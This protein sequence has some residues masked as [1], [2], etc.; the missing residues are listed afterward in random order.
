MQNTQNLST[1]NIQPI[2]IDSINTTYQIHS[3]ADNNET[4]I[5]NNDTQTNNTQ[6]NNNET[7][8]QTTTE[9][10]QNETEKEKDSNIIS[11]LLGQLLS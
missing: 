7:Q 11:D 6:T 4:Q 5:D 3:S 10:N 1:Q 8:S 9:S 2:I